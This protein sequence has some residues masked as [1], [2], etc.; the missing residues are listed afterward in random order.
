MTNQTRSSDWEPCPS[1]TLHALSDSPSAD[2]AS[3]RKFING[4]AAG[5]VL[6]GV[7]LGA[8]AYRQKFQPPGN[9]TCS[10]LAKIVPAYAAKKLDS[11]M[12]H[13]VELHLAKCAHCRDQFE[14]HYA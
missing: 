2:I 9:L 7:G 6:G 4:V 14:Q 8:L 3:R 11:S 13:R 10:Q 5:I 1:G 12:E